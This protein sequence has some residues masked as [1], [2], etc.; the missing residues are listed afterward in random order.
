MAEEDLCDGL[1]KRFARSFLDV[2][3]LHM[4]AR[5]PLWGYRMMTFLRE[6]HGVKVGPP[7]IYPLLDSMQTDGLIDGKDVYA[8]KRKRKMYSITS[9]GHE[10]LKCLEKILSE[11]TG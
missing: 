7:V 11:I 10:N 5:E 2:T 9:K 4:L 1:R 6:R 3:I 8:G